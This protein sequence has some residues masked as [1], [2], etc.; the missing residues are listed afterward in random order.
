MSEISDH[1]CTASSQLT[2]RTWRRIL[3][4]HACALQGSF[5]AIT[6]LSKIIDEYHL[7]PR[8]HALKELRECE[9]EGQ[10]KLEVEVTY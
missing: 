7:S 4:F 10:R 1:R 8:G 2:V 9:Q 3:K 5:L 6:P